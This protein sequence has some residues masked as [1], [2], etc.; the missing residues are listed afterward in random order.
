MVTE[1]VE[2]DEL[3]STSRIRLSNPRRTPRAST[4]AQLTT[5]PM[6]T[7]TVSQKAQAH[8][9]AGVVDGHS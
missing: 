5:T 2:S 3:P 4:A 9:A 1:E 6:T 8:G 7:P